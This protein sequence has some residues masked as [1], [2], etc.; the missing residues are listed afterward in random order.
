M[1]RETVPAQKNHNIPKTDPETVREYRTALPQMAI[2]KHAY[3]G[4]G[5]ERRK[6]KSQLALVKAKIR[7]LCL[8]LYRCPFVC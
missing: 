6:K 7:G 4:W 5:T 3:F 8:L 1:S 2:F